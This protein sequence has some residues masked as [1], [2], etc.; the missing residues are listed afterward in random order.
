MP[1]PG[2]VW[3]DISLD[4]IEG[5]PQS[6]GKDTIL[7]A[8]DRLSK[9]AHFLPLAH[10]FTVASVAQVY[11]E[12][13]F[14]LHGLPKTIFSDRDKIFLSTFW[15]ELFTLQQVDLH[16]STAYHPQS[17]GQ[18]EVVNRCLEGY[19]KCMTGER[20]T[21][22]VLWIPL[23]EW[24]YNTNWHSSTGITPYEVV[25]GQ[26]PSLHIPYVQG[27]SKVEAVDRSLRAREDCIRLLKYHLT[28][29]QQRMKA[30]ADKH[31]SEKVLSIGDWVFVKLQPYQQQSVAQCINQKLAAK[32]FG[33]FE[34][35]A[36][37]GAVAYKLQLPPFSRIHPVFRVS[38]LKKQIGPRPAQSTLPDIDEHGLLAAEPVAVL[39]RKLGRKGNSAVVYV[40]IHWS[41]SPKEDA[42]WELYSDIEKRF[43]H[44]NL[45]AWRQASQGGAIDIGLSPSRVGH[46]IVEGRLLSKWG[47]GCYAVRL[48]LSSVILLYGKRGTYRGY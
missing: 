46:V 25:Y 43:P 36:R 22:W 33:P 19:L 27:D 35:I 9:Y 10:P 13:V 21:E 38:Q 1:I 18:T 2:A 41:H 39:D 29:A 15:K 42:T 37:I 7:V 4:F 24:W 8:V 11:F 30:Q 20:P 16:M 32:Y 28:R 14:R 40:L 17:D 44:F 48:L 12:Q 5:L 23:A 26:P 47:P 31:R 6:R 34:I 45:E 3:V